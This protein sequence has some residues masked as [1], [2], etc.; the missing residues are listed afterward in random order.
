MQSDFS[1]RQAVHDQGWGRL[2]EFRVVYGLDGIPIYGS[3]NTYP[4]I[5]KYEP[6][7]KPC[8]ELQAGHDMQSLS[9]MANCTGI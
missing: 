8:A 4:L 1:S 9:E 2:P 3:T 6:A 5:T 7:L